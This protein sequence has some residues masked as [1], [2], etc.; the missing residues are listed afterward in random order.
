V[1][2]VKTYRAKCRSVSRSGV[3][4][5]HHFFDPLTAKAD[6]SEKEIGGVL[7][8]SMRL[9]KVYHPLEGFSS[10]FLYKILRI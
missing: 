7:S 10:V 3:N 5:R 6:L 8:P 1:S 9:E 2:T 4:F